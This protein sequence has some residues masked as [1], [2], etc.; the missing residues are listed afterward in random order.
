MQ[1]AATV[2]APAEA[3]FGA[4]IALACQDLRGH[5]LP[6]L[7]TVFACGI[8]AYFA[9]PAEPGGAARL[10]VVLAAA[11]LLT[12]AWRGR[13]GAGFL[14]LCCA[15]FL[16]GG[17]AAQTR[18]QLVAGPVL[19]FR[20]YGAVEGRVRAIDRSA[21]GAVRLTLDRVRL[22]RVS[23][24]ETPR[25]VRISLHGG[26]EVPPM[27]GQRIMTTAHLS[28]P[29]GPTEPGGFDFQRHAWFLK[30]GALGYSRVPLLQAAEAETGWA[31][32][33]ASIRQAIGDGLRARLPGQ[34]GAVAAAITTGDRSALSEAV[35]ADLRASNLAHLLAISGLHMGLLVGFVF[36]T[37]RGGLALIPPLALRYP[38]R[39]WAA[40]VALPFALAYLFLSGGGIATQRAFVMAAVMLGAVL[41]GQRALSLRS[42]AIAA[43]I[44]L[45]WRP[46][47]LTG[48]GFQ[49]SF[50]ATG[51]LVLAF[52]RI[53]ALDLGGWTRGWRG[54]VL[55]LLVSSIV[56]GAATAPFAAAHFNRLGQFGV[57]A[58]LLAVPMMGTVVMPLLLV[59]MLLWP[60][61]LEGWALALAGLGIEWILGVAAWV[62]ALPEA[63][64]PVVAPGAAVLPLIGLGMA[65]VG[66]ARGRGRALGVAVFAC[67]L[68]GWAVTV[69]PAV[70]IA[71]DARLVGLAGAEGRWLSRES[72]AGFTAEAWL[73]NDGDAAAQPLAAAR[74]RPG[75][76]DL[77]RLHVA[78][79]KRDL[80]DRAADCA[81]LGGWLITPN[82]P[83]APVAGCRVL[84]AEAL[85]AT[86]TIALYPG[87]DGWWEISARDRQGARPW[88]PR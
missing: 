2:G 68:A 20:Y 32:R 43:L 1:P 70:L 47:A 66:C 17:L 46:E 67:G 12:L 80:P 82:P 5:R 84:D 61:G 81:T 11:A 9:L 37:V 30:L 26:A 56:A 69:R 4:R 88:V 77:P 76:P 25:R 74:A 73:E 19:D 50:A 52:R 10:A 51:A 15:V 49:M 42:V 45:A 64:R 23:Q 8:G 29:A 53:S 83:E 71:E 21:S 60:L 86:G 38:T 79:G 35:V 16:L 39:Q 33:V 62:A 40:G 13:A 31:T 87:K 22:D 59:A 78:R 3:G 72:G 14:P 57:L 24:A 27:P 75:D 48:P 54:A 7:A 44:V 85:R 28:P 6:W 34:P 36:W 41:L 63:V 55:A 65:I 18:T 58:N